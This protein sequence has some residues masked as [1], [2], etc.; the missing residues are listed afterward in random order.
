[1][2]A[3]ISRKQALPFLKSVIENLEVLC[4]DI[5][6]QLGPDMRE[7]VSLIKNLTLNNLNC[8]LLPFQKYNFYA[9]WR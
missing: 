4:G 8:K 7:T 2:S 6:Y 1:M 3:I 5:S 9:I